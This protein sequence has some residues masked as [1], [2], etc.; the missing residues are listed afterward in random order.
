[1][2]KSILIAIIGLGV[3]FSVQTVFAEEELP[4]PE[5]KNIKEW[6]SISAALVAEKRF[7]EAIIYLDKILEQEPDNLKALTN[8]AGLLAQLGNF[9][10]SLDL[11]DKVL[12]ID[13][14]RIS[15]LTNKAIA[16]KM[17]GE[18]EK[19]FEI[20]TKI[21]MIEPNNEK[22]K[23]SR[24]AL[25]SGTPT[26]STNDSIYD[27]HILVVVRDKDEN[28]IAVTESSNA[29]YLP[30]KFTEK[31]WNELSEK[32]YLKYENGYE[33][34]QKENAMISNDD[35]LGILTLEREMSGYNVVMFEAF[36]PMI[37]VE[38]TDTADIQWTIIKK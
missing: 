25:L 37:Q 30:S 21:L 31:W 36:L 38:E 17:L 33:I 14:E 6:E 3:L 35:H 8:K 28:L 12:E 5:G 18:Y 10:K 2:I 29:R 34:F 24:A 16:L 4:L 11:S 27:V 19:S 20:F 1:M 9:S 32:N 23:N 26:I 13:S 15:A 22:I 7:S